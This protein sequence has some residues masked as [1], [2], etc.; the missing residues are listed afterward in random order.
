MSKRYIRRKLQ[1]TLLYL[2]ALAIWIAVV[3][4]MIT[5]WVEHPAEQ[6]IDG[7]AYL[8]SIGGVN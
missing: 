7:R 1:D 6:P 8:E 3:T 5:A 2:C 4:M